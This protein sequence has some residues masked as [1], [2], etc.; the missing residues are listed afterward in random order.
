MADEIKT[1]TPR[2]PRRWLR[3]VGFFFV[4][5]IVGLCIAYFVGT[6]EWALKSIILPKISTA[7]NAKVTVESSSISPFSAVTL[8][9][10]KVETKGPEPLVTAKEVRLR[11]SLMDI[12]KGNIN[13]SEVTLES[14]VVN[15]ITFADGTSNL[16]PITKGKEG[17]KK[18]E[19]K[20][21]K[22]SS[23]PP[24][25]NLQKLALN[26]ATV[27][28]VTERK[29]GT[30]ELLELTGVNVTADDIANGKTGQLGIAANVR[31]NQGLNTASNGVLAAT[32]GGKFNFTFDAALK[33]QVV[34]GQTKVDVTE[35]K[36][37]FAQAAALGV[38]LNAD[39]TPSQ[40]NDVSVQIAQGGKSLG[41]VSA[42]GPFSADTMEGK[43]S[44]NLS[45]IDRQTLNIVGAGMGID[46]NQTTINSTNTI[47]L[48]QRGRVI[49]VSGALM[50][51]NFSATQKGQTTPP[52]DLRTAYAV[53]Y[54]QTNKTALI[55]Q[56]ALNGTQK[57]VEFLRGT[58]AKPMML[59]LGKGSNAV[60]E[61]AFDFVITDFNLPDWQAFIG[62][63][64]TV[65]SGKLGLNLNLI[66]QQAGKKLALTLS[67][68]LKQ[69]T[70]VA[71]S[72]RVENADLAFSTKGTVTEFSAV[73]LEQYRAELA[74]AGQ[75]ALVASGALQYNTKSQDADV[76]AN[77]EV[78]LPQVATL[79]SMPGLNLQAGTIK[80][81]GRIAQKNKTPQQTNN[82]TLDRTVVGKL[83]VD[84]L[85]GQFQSNR[86]DR[87]V[88]AMD[89]DVAMSGTVVD[90][91]KCFGTLQ[92]SGQAGGT[93]DVSGNI[94]T[95]GKV[96]LI[97][98]KLM[99]LN[100]HALKSFVA[101]ALGDKQLESITINSTN[102][103]KMDGPTDMS[104]KADLRVAN[105]VVNDPSGTV[106]KT[107]LGIEAIADVAQVK[108]V[109]DLKTV[110]L[111]LAKTERAPNTL[112]LAGRVDMTKSNAWTGNLKVTSEGMDVTPYYDLFA[113]KSEKTAAPKDSAPVQ[114]VE[115]AP[116]PETEPE[117]MQ[118]PF[119]QFAGDINI[120]KFFLR[121]VAISNLVT[122]ATIDHGRINLNPA[123]LTL[124]GGAVSLIALINVAVRGYQYDI[125]AKMDRV[126]VEPLANTFAPE[127]RGI[128][129]GEIFS[130]V[131]IKGAGLAGPNLK[132]NLGGA[133]GFTLTNAEVKYADAR[134]ENRYL[135]WLVK[136]VPPVARL[137]QAPELADS[138]I[139]L[140][141]SQI[142]ITNGTVNLRRT[143]LESSTYQANVP[144]TITLNE[145]ITN[146]TLNKL[147]VQL[148]L[149]RSLAE[150]AHLA[151]RESGQSPYVEFPSFV[152]IEGTVGKPKY[153]LNEKAVLQLIAKAASGFI[154]GDV[155]N[156]LRNFGN[157]GATTTSTNQ[158]QTN[159]PAASTN[160]V[161][162]LLRGLG[163]AL[164]KPAST[165]ATTNTSATNAPAQKKRGGFNLN[166]ILK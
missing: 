108:G 75:Q 55:Q 58:L 27:R 86:F 41:A 20:D 139:S 32:V 51:A 96:G 166:D 165:N 134:F 152:A 21:E 162:N 153:D 62:T 54:D 85:T 34:K 102:T 109:W 141:D 46:F 138:P 160:S 13:V 28:K 81:A 107:P 36:G 9:G 156:V 1:N 136:W 67:T 148:A 106:P 29:D 60:D 77:L 17:E 10:L 3:L 154:K 8:Q 142:G 84:D 135:G 93:F 129:K 132:K 52:L 16:D 65:S 140:V 37:A 155:G 161:N 31:M 121:E 43:L 149:R 45:Q 56:F 72:N 70:A 94:D 80:F 11:Y 6:S 39:L 145:V 69:L 125:N 97:T 124:N 131:A 126:P 99:D 163:N 49:K 25:V 120:A 26:N 88:T 113:K 33:P 38:T 73:N 42:K 143:L 104:I 23:E 103:V 82:P 119:T 112:N 18:S 150:K 63:N 95:G 50:L 144:G 123:S 76:Q 15:L 7:M 151:A 110:R 61:S 92:Q 164:Q 48:V 79:V 83:N 14:P 35:A 147:P 40:L 105:L 78:A 2:K 157:S 5:M 116:K 57:A 44:V 101:A 128:Y 100:Q 133:I 115:T 59:D 159:A 4:C 114:R 64:A 30:K 158:A 98:A 71:G 74:R 146:S 118:L 53:D 66:S 47:E 89:L 122:K 87:F 130:S 91:K 111:A 127:Q 68:Q 12:I 22:K 90:I 117:P 19:P 24:K 137:L